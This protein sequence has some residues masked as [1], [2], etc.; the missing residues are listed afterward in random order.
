MFILYFPFIFYIFLC[1]MWFLSHFIVVF[2]VLSLICLCFF[3]ICIGKY[4]F[5]GYNQHSVFLIFLILQQ[6]RQPF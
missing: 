3:K 4:Q 1:F 2:V 6:V 5:L